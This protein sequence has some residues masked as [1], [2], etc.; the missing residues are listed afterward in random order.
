MINNSQ[1]GY[2]PIRHD[3]KMSYKDWCD[4]FGQYRWRHEDGSARTYYPLNDNYANIYDYV[5]RSADIEFGYRYIDDIESFTSE[6]L[7]RV[8]IAW[9]KFKIQLEMISGTLDGTNIDPDIFEAGFDRTFTSETK[10]KHS[11]NRTDNLGTR[12]DSVTSENKTTTEDKNRTIEYT[13]GVQ[14]YANLGNDNIGDLGRNYADGFTDGVDKSSGTVNGTSE[15]SIGSQKNDYDTDGSKSEN[16]TE[17][18]H[19]KRISYYDNLA[20]LRERFEHLNE[21]KEFYEYFLPLFSNVSSFS[22]WW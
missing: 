5:C 1:L 20:F 8:P 21:Y 16:H 6:F 14:G 9:A 2:Y 15:S 17:E 11:E 7:A 12:T 19:V 13:Q 4:T 10:G 3:G 22:G 18:E